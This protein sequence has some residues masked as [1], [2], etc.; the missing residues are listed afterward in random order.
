GGQRGPRAQA[1]GA[2]DPQEAPGESD[3]PPRTPARKGR[4]RR[5]LRGCRA[6]P[7]S[8]RRDEGA[9][10]IEERSPIVR[11]SA[12]APGYINTTKSGRLRFPGGFA[13]ARLLLDKS[14][15]TR[16]LTSKP[17]SRWPGKTG[18][19]CRSVTWAR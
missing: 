16:A 9:P 11:Q 13:C 6:A 5:A 17:S 8:D 4:S 3:R 7:R 10:G 19:T 12:S 18:L 14:V 2:G 15:S 1:A